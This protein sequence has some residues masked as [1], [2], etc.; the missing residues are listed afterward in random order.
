MGSRN[1]LTKQQRRDVVAAQGPKVGWQGGMH[2]TT[3]DL[4]CDQVLSLCFAVAMED[5]NRP[6]HQ[7]AVV[8]AL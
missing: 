2:D 5:P 8:A 6:G 1:A 7:R 4:D 3:M